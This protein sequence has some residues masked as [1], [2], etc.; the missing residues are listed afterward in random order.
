MQGNTP[1]MLKLDRG[2]FWIVESDFPKMKNVHE[3]TGSVHQGLK[4]NVLDFQ[5]STGHPR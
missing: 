1:F 4:D 5:G 2:R 3:S